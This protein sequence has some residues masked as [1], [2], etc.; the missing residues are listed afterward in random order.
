MST[1]ESNLLTSLH[2]LISKEQRWPS[3]E[4]KG[5]DSLVSSKMRAWKLFPVI[6]VSLKKLFVSFSLCLVT[7]IKKP[8]KSAFNRG[9]R[10][11]YT[12][13]IGVIW[14]ETFLSWYVELEIY[15]GKSPLIRSDTVMLFND[16]DPRLQNSGTVSTDVIKNED[17]ITDT[18]PKLP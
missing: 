13:H 4:V 18:W 14:N 5:Q 10:E 6:D 2:H 8:P 9:G 16:N 11:T 12:S 15:Y 3:C 7:G 1:W 17:F